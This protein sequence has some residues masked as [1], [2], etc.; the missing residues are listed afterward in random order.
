MIGSTRLDDI[1]RVV[2]VVVDHTP[3]GLGLATTVA[4]G[5]DADCRVDIGSDSGNLDLCVTAL[6]KLNWLPGRRRGR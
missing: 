2:I 3:V 5:R 4:S 6:A 1:I